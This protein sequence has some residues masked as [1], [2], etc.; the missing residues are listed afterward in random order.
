MCGTTTIGMKWT[1]AGRAAKAMF[2]I[3]AL[4]WAFATVA[5][6]PTISVSAKQR[7]PWN[8][9]VDLSFTLTGTGGVL[10]DT[11]FTARDVAGGTNITM[12][13]VRKTDGTAANVAQ[14]RLMPGAYSWVWDAA[15]DLPKDFKCD[16]VTVTG[17]AAVS[18]FSYSVKFNANGGSGTMSNEAFTYG[19]AKAL[20]ANAFTRAGYTFQGWATSASGNKVYNDKQSI[21]N[22]TTTSGAV[23]NLYAVWKAA[24]YMVID[25]SGGANATSYPVSYLDD[26]PS[27]GWSDTYKTTKLV[28]RRV[29]K[30]TNSAGGS[31]AK[32]MW[33]GVFEVTVAQYARVTGL[34]VSVSTGD[35]KKPAACVYR[36][37]TQAHIPDTG[38]MLSGL[39]TK[40]ILNNVRLPT[41]AEWEYACR[42]GTQT[43]YNNGTSANAEN[44]NEVG[45][46]S[47]NST[48]N[49][50]WG[51]IVGQKV[52]NG[53]GL[54]D[55]H[56]N[57]SEMTSSSY[58]MGGSFQS[59]Y[60]ACTSSSG[61]DVGNG[62]YVTV[63]FRVFAEIN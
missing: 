61:S 9:L 26:V 52:P 1:R 10:H 7:Y 18:S 15:A 43:A 53:W 36:N 56:G 39:E 25:L 33:V 3:V 29:V 45:W 54:Y 23:V 40:T 35:N 57:V 41:Q 14:E 49:N 19:T 63:G 11:S 24:L 55:M 59:N 6:E 47:G 4:G 48:G 13:T 37:S 22:L 5:A 58:A 46:W 21:N 16:R 51:L 34:Q 28:L 38:K 30:G 20:T 42:A 2:F 60:G 50:G 44:M 31:M 8:G 62:G 17:S 32:D 27:G 12:A